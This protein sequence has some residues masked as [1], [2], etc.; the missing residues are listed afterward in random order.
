MG[1]AFLPLIADG[2][3]PWLEFE[4]ANRAEMIVWGGCLSLTMILGGLVI[5]I[6]KWRGPLILGSC[7]FFF[8]CIIV[9]T[10]VHF[11]HQFQEDTERF[12]RERDKQV[13]G[14]QSTANQD[15]ARSSK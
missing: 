9:A 10:K 3:T 5:T 15:K 7:L 6:R 13:S 4:H 2:P 12:R 8:G 1:L 11:R 14:E